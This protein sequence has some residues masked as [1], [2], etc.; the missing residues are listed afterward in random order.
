MTRHAH[1]H[2]IA[3]RKHS[4]LLYGVELITHTP[5]GPTSMRATQPRY[6]NNG[7]APQTHQRL[8]DLVYLHWAQCRE[9]IS[10]VAPR[11][12]STSWDSDRETGSYFSALFNQPHFPRLQETRR[13]GRETG[14]K[15]VGSYI[16]LPQG[17]CGGGGENL[18]FIKR[19]MAWHGAGAGAEEMDHV[20]IEINCPSYSGHVYWEHS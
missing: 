4:T 7:E 2:R 13:S 16:A 17:E 9:A 10:V 20:G 8:Y 1:P 11:L 14:W 19:G 18:N 3:E 6:W 15:W 5:K 12:F